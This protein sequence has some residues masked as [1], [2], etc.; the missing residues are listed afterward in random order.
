M[1][2]N[3]ALSDFV[4][5]AIREKASRELA[6]LNQ[7]SLAFSTVERIRDGLL[8]VSQDVAGTSASVSAVSNESSLAAKIKKLRKLVDDSHSLASEIAETLGVDSHRETVAASRQ[9]ILDALETAGI[10]LDSMA[11]DEA[12]MDD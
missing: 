7:Q 8:A 2:K 6:A 1:T 11:S 3:A 5:E 9:S 10:D 12:S 4:R